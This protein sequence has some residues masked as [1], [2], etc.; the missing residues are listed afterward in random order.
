MV[1]ALVH[2]DIIIKTVNP[3][4]KFANQLLIMQ[5]ATTAMFRTKEK[6]METSAFVSIIITMLASPSVNHAILS[7]KPVLV[8][9][10]TIAHHAMMGM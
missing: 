7:V 10:K 1:H 4:A 2:Q 9:Q 6:R 5:L 3:P 8:Q